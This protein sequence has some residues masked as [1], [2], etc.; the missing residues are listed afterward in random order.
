ML[1]KIAVNS[2]AGMPA[3]V[4]PAAV[5]SY[6]TE[7]FVKQII[8]SKILPEGALQLICGNAGDL[9]DHLTS[10]DV[11]TFTG[12]ATTGLMLKS[13][14]NIL[15]E[16][17]PFI[18]EADSLNC[19]VLGEDITPG[20]PEWN[21][22]VKEVRKEMTLKAGQRCTGI[23]RIFVLENK[24]KDMCKAIST[25]LSQTTVGNPLNEKVCMW[26]LA[27]ETQ[28]NEVREQVL[29]LLSSSQIVY[30]SLDSV[31]VIDGDA[32]KGAFLSPVLLLN[33]KPFAS[34]EVHSVEAF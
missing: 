8:A 10:L 22:F 31:A 1:E 21:I 23:R 19:I 27:G 4:K 11:V 6:L 24:I 9:L 29:K 30:G 20:K 33:D 26:S 14:P 7:A 18:M 5:T 15:K 13:T 2:L 28:R 25:A 12:S 17:V 34:Q 32:V 16:A 3:I